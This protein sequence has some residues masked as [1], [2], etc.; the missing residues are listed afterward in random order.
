ML[1][2]SKALLVFESFSFNFLKIRAKY[3]EFKERVDFIVIIERNIFSLKSIFLKKKTWVSD[4][5]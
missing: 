2:F 5:F 1:E 4:K 3:S